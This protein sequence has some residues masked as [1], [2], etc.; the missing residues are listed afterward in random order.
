M[1]EDSTPPGPVPS[2][3]PTPGS[4]LDHEKRHR[5]R[6]RDVFLRLRTRDRNRHPAA[7]PRHTRIRRRG[8]RSDRGRGR[9]AHGHGYVPTP[10]HAPLA[11]PALARRSS[12]ARG[13]TAMSKL[14]PAIGTNWRYDEEPV[15]LSRGDIARFIARCC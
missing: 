5:D 13:L 11:G 9:L 15:R 8:A 6:S 2:S 1:T 4:P 10:A 3:G 12:A 7:L 14:V